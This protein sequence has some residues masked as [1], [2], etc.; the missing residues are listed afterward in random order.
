MAELERFPALLES[1]RR[2]LATLERCR[3][4]VERARLL[5]GVD[6]QNMVLFALCKA[7]QASVDL[8]RHAIAERSLRVPTT[9]RAVFRVLADA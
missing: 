6:T 1:L 2:A 8:G 3:E 7:A 4:S 9:Y 5:A